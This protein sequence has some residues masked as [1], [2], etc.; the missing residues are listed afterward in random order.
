MQ[1]KIFGMFA[2]PF[3][4]LISLFAAACVYLRSELVAGG[5]DSFA[6][7]TQDYVPMLRIAHLHF[8]SSNLLLDR[9]AHS[10]FFVPSSVHKKRPHKAVSFWC[11]WGECN[12]GRH[13]GSACWA[14]G[15]RQDLKGLGVLAASYGFGSGSGSRGLGARRVQGMTLL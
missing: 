12:I 1:R 3:L 7:R 13:S 4:H 5:I 15:D 14:L 2:F 8:A 10:E 6:S 11:P 9:F